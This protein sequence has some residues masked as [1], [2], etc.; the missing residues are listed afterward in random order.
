MEIKN[1][2]KTIDRLL[3]VDPNLEGKLKP[4]KNKSKRWPKKNKDYW[5]ELL[6]FL[7]SEDLMDHPQRSEMRKIFAPKDS[8]KTPNYSFTEVMPGDKIVGALPEN[9]ADSIRRLDLN[10]I[11]VAKIHVE[12]NI[13]RN[14]ELM[15]KAAREREKLFITSKSTWLKI[16]DHFSLWG[17]PLNHTIKNKDGTLYL[18]EFSPN[19]QFMGEGL[20]KMDSRTLKE[21]FKYL[22]M[23]P[24]QGLFGE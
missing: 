20:V 5:E 3:K 18:I 11:K 6:N 1:L 2:G 21:F 13:T 12:A 16:K 19:P 23:D 22:K 4:I 9:L 14:S 7:N 15:I 8:S 24:P 10:N 17:V